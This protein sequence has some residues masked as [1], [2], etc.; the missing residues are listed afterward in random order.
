MIAMAPAIDAL[1]DSPMS[2]KSRNLLAPIQA[3]NMGF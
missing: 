1:A 3:E 2:Q